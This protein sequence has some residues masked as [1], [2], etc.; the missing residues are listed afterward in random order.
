MK[1]F[2]SP[3]FG[4]SNSDSEEEIDIDIEPVQLTYILEGGNPE[5]LEDL[6]VYLSDGESVAS[7]AMEDVGDSDS[8]S[9]FRADDSTLSDSSLESDNEEETA[10]GTQ[11]KREK[12]E[13]PTESEGTTEDAA[14]RRVIDDYDEE[15][16]ED[17]VIKAIITEIK[18]PRSKPPNIQT[19][20]FIIDLSFHPTED[21]LAVGTSVGDVLMYKYANE[22]NVLSATQELHT[23]SVRCVEFAPD[24]IS[25]I[26][27]GR[28]R[29]I[30]VMDVE[31]G[32]FKRFWENAHDEPVYSMAVVGQHLFTTGDD[33]GTLKLWDVRQRDAVF[34][35]RPVEDFIS[36]ILANH[37]QQKYLLM[38]SGDGLLTTINIAQ[39]KM[40]VQSEPYEE[41]LN[42]MGLY[43]RESKL[44]VGTSKGNY[45][46]FNWG[47]FAYH[48]DAF[49]G[50]PASANRMVPITEQI[51][52]LAGEDGIIRAMHLVPGRVLGIVGQHS[53]AVDTLDISGNGELIATSS[54][55][56]DVRFWNIKYFENFDGIKYNSK[57]DKRTLQHN[58]PSSQRTN[59]RDFFAGLDE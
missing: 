24:G 28:E 38:T 46:T 45:Y 48:C 12:S 40:Y 16:E 6:V 3:H 57:P 25:L 13:N 1:N 51:G 4:A 35:L 34:S 7:G 15:M 41:E 30:V 22:A 8:D 19:E 9:S 43:K 29:S 14:P 33:D 59:A 37:H 58:L 10:E 20:D 36:S 55:D 42:C 31:T 39:R 49:T 50:P 27:T 2:Q 17:E 56:N 53:M 44:V 18:K 11:S 23:K 52:V 21:I 47:Q 5:E 32:K 26:S 54:H